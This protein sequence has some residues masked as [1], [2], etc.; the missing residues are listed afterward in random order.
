MKNNESRSGLFEEIFKNLF[1]LTATRILAQVFAFFATVYVSRV[2][3]VEQYGVLGFVTSILVYFDMASNLGLQLFSTREVARDPAKLSFYVWNTAIIRILS[4]LVSIGIIS[5][6]YLLNPG[7]ISALLLLLYSVSLIAKAF[8]LNWVFTAH[9]RMELL[10]ITQGITQ[11]IYM[12]GCFRLVNEPTD[13]LYVPIAFNTAYISAVL[14][15]WIVLKLQKKNLSFTLDVKM[16]KTMLKQSLPMIMSFIVIRIYMNFSLIYL[17]FLG[18]NETLGYYNAAYK[19]FFLLFA[20]REILTSIAFPLMSKLFIESHEKLK[21][22]MQGIIRVSLLFA[23]PVFIGGTILSREI[24]LFLFS[25][26]Y[27][28][29]FLPFSIMLL[30]YLFMM[31]NILF[32]S[33]QNAFNN[34]KIYF[35]ISIIN[36]ITSI[37]ANIILIYYFGVIGAALAMATTELQALILYKIY[38]NKVV[39]LDIFKPFFHI[40]LP[41]LVM[42]VF[43]IFLPNIFIFYKIGLSMLVY[44]TGLFLFRVVN[45][46]DIINIKHLIVRK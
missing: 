2:V 43:L 22:V 20:V 32:P 3:G 6:I 23:I 11:F 33:A 12:L 10:G 40:L 14:F 24:I 16:W 15:T 19:I 34:Q 44:I 8:L 46:E 35:K 27:E 13:V 30:S 42:G 7:S 18:E 28:A 37:V 5:V 41:G 36:S 4:S 39:N 21:K 1:S 45:T 25:Q 38:T 17:G 9:R 29:A 26:E 31:I